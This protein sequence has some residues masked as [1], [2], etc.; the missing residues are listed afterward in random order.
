MLFTILAMER[1]VRAF[2]FIKKDE[3]KEAEYMCVHVMYVWGVCTH[4]V[5]VCVQVVCL[6]VHV[7]G[8][9]VCMWCVCLCACIQYV[10]LSTCHL[11]LYKIT[12]EEYE[13]N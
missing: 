1:S 13:T 6:Y 12:L 11:S 5:C 8:G 7:E 2:C 9:V 4:V 3:I 10:H